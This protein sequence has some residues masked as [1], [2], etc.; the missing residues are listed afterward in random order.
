[1]FIKEKNEEISYHATPTSRRFPHPN[2]IPKRKI[3][4]IDY[5]RKVWTRLNLVTLYIRY[6]SQLASYALLSIKHYECSL[7][8]I[9]ILYLW[10]NYGDKET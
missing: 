10:Y 4:V 8:T 3:T 2:T 5:I 9:I 7:M 1:M 6:I